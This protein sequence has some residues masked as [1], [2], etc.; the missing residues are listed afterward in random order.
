MYN[1]FKK[2]VEQ[3]KQPDMTIYHYEFLGR[4]FGLEEAKK[5]LLNVVPPVV[6]TPDMVL[7][8]AAA[9]EMMMGGKG[10][11]VFEKAVWFKLLTALRLSLSAKTLEDREGNRN[12]VL[13]LLGCLHLPYEMR[14]AADNIKKMKEIEKSLKEAQV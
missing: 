2:S 4:L 9:L 6:V 12:Q 11:S 10:W 14:F 8:D 7:S 1:P 3:T 13:A 5:N